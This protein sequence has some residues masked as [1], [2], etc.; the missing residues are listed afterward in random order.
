MKKNLFV[1]GF[2]LMLGSHLHSQ[3]NGKIVSPSFSSVSQFVTSSFESSSGF[4]VLT[5]RSSYKLEIVNIYPDGVNAITTELN[6]NFQPGESIKILGNKSLNNGV[7]CFRSIA[8]KAV[9]WNWDRDSKNQNR[10]CE[11]IKLEAKMGKEVCQAINGTNSCFSDAAEVLEH[12]NWCDNQVQTNN[13]TSKDINKSIDDAFNTV[14]ENIDKSQKQ[15]E[16]ESTIEPTSNSNSSGS[17]SKDM[18]DKGVYA[19]YTDHD[20][21]NALYWYLKSAKDGYAE[22]MSTL[23]IP[24]SK[25]ILLP[26]IGN[27]RFAA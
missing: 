23:C 6:D 26:M 27:H 21:N 25:H 3:V 7:R 15:E 11:I 18:F 20:M 10:G 14:K 4:I 24:P 8:Y 5:N 9:D 13:N 12:N 17:S 16:S 1:V 2:L 22:A 19:Q